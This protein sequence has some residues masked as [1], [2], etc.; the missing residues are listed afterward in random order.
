MERVDKS[1]WTFLTNHAHVLLCLA[2]DTSM[3]IRDIADQVGITERAV[4]LILADLEEDG[5]LERHREGRCN[6]YR[7]HGEL[8]LRH[9]IERHRTIDDL[10]KLIHGSPISDTHE[11][12][13]I[14]DAKGLLASSS[15][16]NGEGR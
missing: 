9:P 12:S 5:Y 15:I 16:K 13:D 4:Q 11:D 2:R 14:T 8:H 6:Y 1:N 7:V 10:I 3:R